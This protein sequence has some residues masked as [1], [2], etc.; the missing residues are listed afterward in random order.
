MN[1]AASQ[2]DRSLG[3]V[4]AKLGGIGKAWAVGLVGGI[5]GGF[6]AAGISGIVA[7]VGRIANGVAQ[8]GDEA[9]R[10]GVSAKAFQEWKFVADQNRIGVDAL[11]DG[12]KELNLRADEFAIT[13][14]GSA[15][16]AFARL[17][18]GAEEVKRK[19]EDPSELLLEIIGR[20]GQMDKAAQIRISDELF[21]GTAGERFVELLDQGEAGIRR[22]I[23]TANDLGIVMDDELIAKAAEVDRQFN[24]V[25]TTVGTAL[26]SAIVSAASSLTDFINRFRAFEHQ[27]DGQLRAQQ[28]SLTGEMADAA[29]QLRRIDQEEG[30]GVAAPDSNTWSQQRA[31][32]EK[33]IADRKAQLAEIDG[34][35]ND[36]RPPPDVMAGPGDTT[37]TPPAYTPPSADEPGGRRGG[38]RSGAAERTSDLE[39]EIAALLRRTEALKAGT[40][41]QSEIN[42]LL[43]DFGHAAAEA[44]ARTD[45]LVAAQQA[46]IP[47][48]AELRARIDELAA[49]YADAT[50]AAAELDAE[51]EE[52]ARKAEELAELRNETIRGFAGDLMRGVDA[53]DALN[54]ALGR[55]G[56]RLINLALDAVFPASGGGGILGGLF[57]G[58]GFARGTA[59]TGGRRGE[60]RGVVHG[61]EAVI[62]LPDGGRVPVD[63]R[64]PAAA[65]APTVTLNFSPT[66]NAPGADASALARVEA[67]LHQ[68]QSEFRGM[69]MDAVSQPRMRGAI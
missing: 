37:W 55:L 64:A 7:Q 15:A 18:Y 46:G 10:A 67:Q 16:E 26:K 56:D 63:V 17:G 49:G 23:R 32:W 19:L 8:V 3:A 51:Q 34:V 40:L 28:L 11:V 45:L 27:R 33:V 42:P 25:A 38:G 60:P 57:G 68:M 31:Q 58:R 1:R 12:L 13:G 53:A 66:I 20:L 22:T 35:L 4:S 6:A 5:A 69:V 48:T 21:G 47:V 43:Q 30:L 24:I 29:T 41:A 50:A 62:P 39:R 9:R 52:S 54:A 2:V 59:N 65:A 14:K 36:R 44:A 61:Q